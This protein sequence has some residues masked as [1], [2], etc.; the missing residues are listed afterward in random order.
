MHIGMNEFRC[1]DAAGAMPAGIAIFARLAQQVAGEC[2]CSLQLAGPGRSRKKQCMRYGIPVGVRP[3]LPDYI[4]VP[5]NV[6]KIH[7]SYK[8]R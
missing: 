1:L 4:I 7:L 8:F 3:E 6:P 2:Y 5:D